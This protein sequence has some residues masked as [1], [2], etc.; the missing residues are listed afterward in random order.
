LKGPPIYTSFFLRV[1]LIYIASIV[2]DGDDLFGE[3]PSFKST[4]AAALDSLSN[5]TPTASSMKDSRLPADVVGMGVASQPGGST[6]FTEDGEGE[7]EEED[8]IDDLFVAAVMSRVHMTPAA[9]LMLKA[10]TA[11]V[12]RTFESTHAPPPPP[13]CLGGGYSGGAAP[14]SWSWQQ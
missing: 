9:S 3:A 6:L 5:D 10:H 13:L 14:K 7:G 12:A 8:N 4:T 1:V 2:D 11:E